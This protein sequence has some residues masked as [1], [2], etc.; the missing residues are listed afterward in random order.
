MA[1]KSKRAKQAVVAAVSRLAAKTTDSIDSKTRLDEIG[2]SADLR[3]VLNSSI[4]AQAHMDGLSLEG[5]PRKL[6]GDTVGELTDSLSSLVTTSQRRADSAGGYPLPAIRIDVKL[7]M[8]R[9]KHVNPAEIKDDDKLKVWNFT[10]IDCRGLAQMLN[11]YYFN[12][13]AI[14]LTPWIHPS[15][16]D[17][18]EMTVAQVAQVVS[19]HNPTR[20]ASNSSTPF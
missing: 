14:V 12:E 6:D 20:R 11:L 15:E 17:N 9:I 16:T 3:K 19:S 7:V 2:V 18:P 1:K 13:R 8:A 5:R 4:L 10:R